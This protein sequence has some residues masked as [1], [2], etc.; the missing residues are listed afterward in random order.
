MTVS[1]ARGLR[2]NDPCHLTSCTLTL[3]HQPPRPLSYYCISFTLLH[4]LIN[5]FHLTADALGIDCWAEWVNSEANLADLPSRPAHQWEQLCA[6]RPVFLHRRMISPSPSD[7]KNSSKLFLSL[8]TEEPTSQRTPL[9]G[10]S[11]CRVIRTRGTRRLYSLSGFDALS[12]LKPD[13]TSCGSFF[14]LELAF[15]VDESFSIFS[16]PDGK[17]LSFTDCVL[18]FFAK[19]CTLLKRR[20][21]DEFEFAGLRLV[22]RIWADLQRFGPSCQCVLLKRVPQGRTEI[23]GIVLTANAGPR[24]PSGGDTRRGVVLTDLQSPI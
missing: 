22:T 18:Q 20:K 10:A 16:L 9:P 1:T 3:F 5:L 14:A 15:T 8:K 2:I 13:V 12:P 11:C 17:P 4:P 19:N 23:G 7:Y 24:V 6:A 21:R